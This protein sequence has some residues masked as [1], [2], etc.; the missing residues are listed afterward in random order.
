VR[1]INRVLPG[2][3]RNQSAEFVGVF[4]PGYKGENSKKP[5][6]QAILRK[7]SCPAYPEVPRRID[8][9]CHLHFYKGFP[10]KVKQLPTGVNSRKRLTP[11]PSTWIHLVRLA[12]L[13]K[14]Q[15][16]RTAKLQT[17]I[18]A[19]AKPADPDERRAWG[20]HSLAEHTK[21]VSVM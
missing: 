10:Q 7:D 13:F 1:E 3:E 14:R 5:K 21:G 12:A 8:H 20:T 15:E 18:D 17:V 16:V 6:L 11:E 19:S 4:M 9:L 2:I